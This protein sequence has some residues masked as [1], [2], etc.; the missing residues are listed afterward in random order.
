[1]SC[2]V[3]SIR[4]PMLLPLLRIERW[5]R[6]AALGR[7]V[8]PEVNWMLM[9]S[10]GWRGDF[11]KGSR[12]CPE[13]RMWLYSVMGLREEGLMRPSELLTMMICWSDGTT[14]DS[15]FGDWRSGM[16]CWSSGIFDRGSF[17]GRFVSV[18]MMRWEA[19]R[20]LRAE[21]TCC[22]LKLGFRGT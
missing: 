5:E 16:I 1:M 20:W 17:L 15:S 10:L 8:V 3:R 19:S 21:M 6:Q 14:L 4:S 18:P 9:V 13:R 12:L 2:G 11:G 7:E 22:E